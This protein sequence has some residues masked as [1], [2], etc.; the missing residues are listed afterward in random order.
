MI[1]T[2]LFLGI[3]LA[4]SLV[5]IAISIYL[6]RQVLSAKTGN[7]ATNEVGDAI[8]SGA[9][10]YLKRQFLTI[11]PIVL[12]LAIFLYA[13]ADNQAL[14]VGRSG[15]FLLGSF[16]SALIGTVGMN[17]A[18]RANVRVAQAAKKGFGEAMELSFR[19]GAT[20][21]MLTVG[22]GLLGAT[23]I[24]WYYGEH[25]T[26]V[27]IGFGFGGSL[28]ALFMRVGGGIYTKAADVGADL[29]GKIEKGIPEDDPRN[30]A[31][32]ADLVG[33]NVG[34]CA[35]MAADLF[36]SY[37]VTLVAAM[38][39]G[40]ATFGLPGVLFPLAVRALGVFTSTIGIFAVRA[41]GKSKINEGVNAILRAFAI[42]AIV[43]IGGFFL[44][45][46]EVTGGVDLA[47]ATTVGV[48]LS[49][50]IFVLTDYATGDHA[51]AKEIARQSQTGPA[52][53]ILAG[54]VSGFS[55]TVWAILAIG[56]TILTSFLIFPDPLM[57]AYGVALAGMGMLTTTGLIVSMDS[58]GPIADNAQ[59]IA[60]LAGIKD[61]SAGILHKLDSIGNTTKATTKGFAIASAV[62]AAVSLF[63]SFLTDNGLSSIDVAHPAVFVGLLIGGAIPFL[64]S[65]L[66]I[67]AVS[68]STFAV[69]K[70]V[71]RQFKEMP[72]IMKGTQKPDYAKV[73]D[74]TTKAA[75]GALAAPALV[76]IIVPILVGFLL[77]AEALGG[78]LAGT[79]LTGQLLAVFMSNTGGAW[80]NAKK[81][82]EDGLYGGKGSDE[83]KA[84]IVGDI[85]G[86]PLKDT[87]GP[88]I[89]PL[90][91]VMNL[92][93]L[94]V[95]PL[96]V[97]TETLTFVHWIGI[98][99][100]FLVLAFFVFNAQRTNI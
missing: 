70:E 49:I 81:M 83:H 50:V 19:A 30:A 21:G 3:I 5:G 63:E 52:T 45:S 82:I 67:K 40:A 78:F 27:L 22:L 14:A 24:Y 11:V 15:A 41:K 57:A 89:N 96:I 75:L 62:V 65:S 88:A 98:M 79:I 95:A 99:S 33:D 28:L 16:F 44:L 68:D 72:G 91:K 17:I 10:A 64:F 100:A 51:P 53:V 76:A 4:S 26:E 43:S 34:D 32:I 46:K 35:G 60:E 36:E 97:A 74:L 37:E 2:N 80:D 39:L 90:I 73:V 94:L 29:V 18:T 87:S 56:V 13:T 47:F 69:I 42:S 12:I 84:T 55:S 31:V 48:I 85:V 93:A 86:D 23:L 59:G 71:R 9:N 25:A 7:E 6:A 38:I 8:R 92:V 61:K 58:Y 66:T 20:T 54:L 1:D 77:K